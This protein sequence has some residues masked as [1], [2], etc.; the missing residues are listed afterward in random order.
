M[1]SHD[2][3]EHITIPMRA[4]MCGTRLFGCEGVDLLYIG[5][6][7]ESVTISN[8]AVGTLEKVVDSFGPCLTKLD[9]E[10]GFCVRRRFKPMFE[11]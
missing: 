2:I 8:F 11:S 6:H 5:Y 10:S 7:F 4:L 3:P 1:T 9:I